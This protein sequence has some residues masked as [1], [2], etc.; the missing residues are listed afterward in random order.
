MPKLSAL[1]SGPLW[2]RGM[3]FG[4]HTQ[5]EVQFPE[6]GHSVT[7]AKGREVCAG[8]LAAA[9]SWGDGHLKLSAP[10]RQVQILFHLLL[11]EHRTKDP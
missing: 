4:H 11:T 2:G 9:N 3:Q 6:T 5:S 1:L 10:Q 8:L 7:P